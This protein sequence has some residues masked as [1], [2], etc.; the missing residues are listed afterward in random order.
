MRV[1]AQALTVVQVVRPIHTICGQTVD[2]MEG[3]GCPVWCISC[4]LEHRAEGIQHG[5]LAAKAVPKKAVPKKL[6]DVGQNVLI[7]I[8]IVDRRSLSDPQNLHGVLL[9]RLDDGMYQIGATHGI[10]ENLY[11]SSQLKSSLSYF[12]STEDVPD[13][14][15]TI[16][17]SIL[18]N[19]FGRNK[20]QCNC[21]AAVIRTGANASVLT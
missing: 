2:D 11:I 19:S 12:L 13:N 21:T 4:S 10:L 5:R 8:P 20:L 14:R 18:H 3:Y 9:Q 15:V 1:S 16:K 17:E 7:P 6:V